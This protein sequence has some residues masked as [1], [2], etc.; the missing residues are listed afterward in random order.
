MQTKNEYLDKNIFYGLTNL[1][2]GFDSPSIK[3]FSA[4][5]FEIILNRVKQ[6]GL[7]IL[8]IEPWKNGEFYSVT[9]YEDETNDPTDSKWYRNAFENFRK[10]DEALQYAATYFIPDELLKS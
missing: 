4:Q 2:D 8:G 3:Y 5:D 10:E 9:I 7:G 1:N 6:L